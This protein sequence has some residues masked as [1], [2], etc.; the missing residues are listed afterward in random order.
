M[1]SLWPGEASLGMTGVLFHILDGKSLY[2]EFLNSTGLNVVTFNSSLSSP[3]S[4]Y[5]LVHTSRFL[6]PFPEIFHMI[7]VTFKN[8]HL[9]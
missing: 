3:A 1:V 2:P 9:G 8:L 5:V 7:N 6:Q 4:Q